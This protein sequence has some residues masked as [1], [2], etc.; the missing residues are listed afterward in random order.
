VNVASHVF[1]SDQVVQNTALDAHAVHRVPGKPDLL[2]HLF[3][4][5]F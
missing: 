3:K 5:Y 4:S 2:V 1:H